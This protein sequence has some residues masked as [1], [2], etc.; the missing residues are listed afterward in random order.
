V[1]RL[2]PVQADDVEALTRQ[3]TDEAAAGDFL[4]WGFQTGARFRERL[5][6]NAL[7][8]DDSGVLALVDD[9]ENLV[10]EVSWHAVDNTTPPHGRCWNLG[11][12]LLPDARGR[13]VGTAAH[14]ALAEYLFAHT[15]YERIEAGTEVDNI[16]EQRALEKAGFTKE[17]VLRR[18]AFRAG[19]YRDMV[20]YSKLRGEP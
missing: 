5:A 15:S 14:R 20:I 1:I 13:G 9:A 8:G 2:R 12:W 16:A 3:Y 10:G 19:A 11:I 4:W 17:G 6:A 18:A 7:I